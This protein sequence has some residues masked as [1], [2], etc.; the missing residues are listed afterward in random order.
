[1][2]Q[3]LRLAIQAQPDRTIAVAD[4]IVMTV[5]GTK[6]ANPARSMNKKYPTSAR[7]PTNA[8]TQ[9]AVRFCRQINIAPTIVTI[10][11]Q[12]RFQACWLNTPDTAAG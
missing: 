6:L 1:M 8:V 3:P 12:A 5:P 10:P 2:F 11:N 4:T 9:M 7:P